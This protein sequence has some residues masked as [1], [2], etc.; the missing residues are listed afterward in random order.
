MNDTLVTL[1]DE[2]LQDDLIPNDED[3]D[4]EIIDKI[5]EYKS[6]KDIVPEPITDKKTLEAT[7]PEVCTT[8]HT[9]K[10]VISAPQP[11]NSFSCALDREFWLNWKRI[12]IDNHYETI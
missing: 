9:S 12:L 10:E 4:L 3:I 11:E 2:M 5:S 6:P 1:A 7:L 8:Q